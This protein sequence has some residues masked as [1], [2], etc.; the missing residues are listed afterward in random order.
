MNSDTVNRIFAGLIVLAVGTFTVLIVKDLA[1][2]KFAK[3]GL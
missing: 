2:E 1:K 3:L